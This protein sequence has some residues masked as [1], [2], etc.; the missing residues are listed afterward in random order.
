MMHTTESETIKRGDLYVGTLLIELICGAPRVII[1]FIVLA[2][3]LLA[4]TVARTESVLEYQRALFS[5]RQQLGPIF[6]FA[7]VCGYANVLASLVA[8]SGSGSGSLLTRF[9]L[10]ARETSRREQETLDQVFARIVDQVDFPVD[11][12]SKL[13]V[14]DST[15]E[16]VNL[17]GTTV[18]V[19][20]GAI[21]GRHLPAL[22]AHE[23]GHLN[24]GDGSR[25]LALRRL[26]FPPFQVF[27]S[28]IRDFSTSRPPYRP[29][30]KEFDAEQIYYAIV[31]KVLFFTLAFLG[32]GIGVWVLSWSWASHFRAKDYEADAFTVRL[33]YKD[34][35]IEY[36]EENKFYDAA[37]PYMLGWRPANELRIDRLLHLEESE[38]AAVEDEVTPVEP[39]GPEAQMG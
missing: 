3:M 10:G 36:L 4:W 13:Y 37:V 29:E 18:Y 25:I 28:G 31:N 21:R 14:V 20:S 39:I 7:L 15:L 30:L 23:L 24:Q 26:V 12:F 27:I 19:S 38:A 1:L 8:Y 5:F 33:G 16:W 35:L 9:V 22:L 32:G 17:I 2:L 34:E 6:L 11:S